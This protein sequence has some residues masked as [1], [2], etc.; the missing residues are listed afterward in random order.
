MDEQTGMIKAENAYSPS[1]SLSMVGPST[2][3]SSG[4]GGGGGETTVGKQDKTVID[5]KGNITTESVTKTVQME[6]N[7]LLSQ[8]N[9]YSQ[10]SDSAFRSLC[11]K[12]LWTSSF[13]DIS[14]GRA[15][16]KAKSHSLY[17]I[18][19]E[20]GDILIVSCLCLYFFDI[21]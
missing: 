19:P 2:S 4:G 6:G 17:L 13:D 7:N 16:C 18:F 12:P 8:S 10:I 21:S 3:A 1:N 9:G 20:F 15:S 5:E 14:D 11:G